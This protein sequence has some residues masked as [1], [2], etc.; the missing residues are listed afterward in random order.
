MDYGYGFGGGMGG[1]PM[2]GGSRPGSDPTMLIV[3]CVSFACAL[4]VMIGGVGWAQG[5]FNFGTAT[6]APAP[7]PPDPSTTTDTSTDTTTDTTDTSGGVGAAYSGL[8][9]MCAL[10]YQ[11]VKDVYNAAVPPFNPNACQGIELQASCQ[12]WQSAQQTPNN[13]VWTK[14]GV[15]DGCIPVAPGSQA[16]GAPLVGGTTTGLRDPVSGSILYGTVTPQP[17]VSEATAAGAGKVKYTVSKRSSKEKRLALVA[18]GGPKIIR[19]QRRLGQPKKGGPKNPAPKTTKSKR[20]GKHPGSPPAPFVSPAF[21][22]P[23]PY[24]TGSVAYTMF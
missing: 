2:M 19:K 20:R 7:T 9:T 12:Y 22:G 8:P 6:T 1:M 14:T 3:L 21:S 17:G 13:W 18:A 15:V 16:V 5:W 10:S 23:A 4:S 24:T 11:P